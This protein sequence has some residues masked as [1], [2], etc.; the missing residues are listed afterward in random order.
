MKKLNSEFRIQNEESRKGFS[1]CIL[2]SA[3]CIL[4]SGG[5]AAA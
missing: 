4:H 5:G 2:N 3:F 1:F